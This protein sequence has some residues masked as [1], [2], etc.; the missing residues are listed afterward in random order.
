MTTSTSFENSYP[1]VLINAKIVDIQDLTK[2]MKKIVI[3]DGDF[4]ASI[5]KGLARTIKPGTFYK[6]YYPIPDENDEYLNIIS[7]RS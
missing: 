7:V 4:E 1:Y 6:L 3:N 5:H 2:N